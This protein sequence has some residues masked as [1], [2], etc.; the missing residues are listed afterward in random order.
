MSEHRQKLWKNLEILKIKKCSIHPVLQ[1]G[2]LIVTL[3][4][5]TRAAIGELF[6]LDRNLLKFTFHNLRIIVVMGNWNC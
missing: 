5:Y 6:L 1:P 2:R 4:N 3:E